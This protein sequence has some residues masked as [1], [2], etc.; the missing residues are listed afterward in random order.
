MNNS[1]IVSSVSESEGIPAGKVRKVILA[2]LE[3]MGKAVD[4]GERINFPGYALNPRTTPA[5][6]AD[7]DRPARAETRIGIF[8]RRPQKKDDDQSVLVE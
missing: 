7:G 3:I 5:K 4:E 6:E 2:V 1:D 8:R